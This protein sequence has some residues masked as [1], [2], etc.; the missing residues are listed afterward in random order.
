MQQ[1]KELGFWMCTALVIGN[2]IGV[3]IYVLPAS[4]APYGLNALIGWAITVLGM[5]FLARVF[6]QL[7]REFPTAD[8]PQVYIEQTSGSLAAFVSVWCYWISVF[9]TNAALA[10]GVVGYLVNVVPPLQGVPPALLAVALLWLFVG[11]NLLGLRTGGGVQIVTTALKLLPMLFL[12]ALGAWLLVSEPTIYTRHPPP[13][14]ISLGGLMAA[15][16]IALFAMLGIESAAVPAGR[17]R[18]PQRTIPRSTMLGTLLTAAI[19]IV[20]S[21]MALLLMQQDRLAQSSA[22]F[23]ELLGEFFGSDSGRWL[24]VFVVVSG[25]GTLNGWTLLVGE[26]TASLGRHGY[27]P[28][29]VERLNGRGAPAVGLVAS[30]L[31]ATPMVLMNY[32]KSLVDGFTF[33]TQVVTAANLPLYFF[34]AFALVVMAK[35][36]E[37]RP[38]AKLLVLG[39]LGTAYSVF[40]F[41]GVGREPFVWALVLGATALP[42][43]WY[44]RRS[45]PAIA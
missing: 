41:V 16:T 11:V 35:R 5:T 30:G 34:C 4:L 25:L 31:L 7:A 24:S 21:T 13:T 9:I 39:L 26:L 20:V 8:G 43:Y 38:P 6:A 2:T 44:A 12:M 32:S 23:A 1:G 42:V 17:V 33:L 36:G 29:A 15:S 18:D 10:I 40:A 37:R 45:R 3:G 22:P 14:P 28:A 19:Y 27:L